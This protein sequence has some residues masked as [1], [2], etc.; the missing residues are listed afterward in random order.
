MTPFDCIEIRTFM[1]TV[2][3]SIQSS[4]KNTFRDCCPIVECID[5]RTLNDGTRIPKAERRQ[6]TR[7]DSSYP[8]RLYSY[9]NL[10]MTAGVLERHPL[11]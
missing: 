8:C 4:S 10:V 1:L 11:A 6:Q 2:W 7:S 5:F 9:T 3:I